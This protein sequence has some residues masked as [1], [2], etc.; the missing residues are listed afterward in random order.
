MSLVG[1]RIGAA[2]AAFVMVCAAPSLAAPPRPKAVSTPGKQTPVGSSIAIAVNGDELPPNPSPRIVG[3]GGG[4][5]V[6]P[7]VRIYSALGIAVSR[8][9][10]SITASAPGK[11]I[12][13]RI[14]SSHATIDGRPVIMEAPAMTIDNATYVPL[15]FVAESLGA[16]ATFNRHANRV[17]VVSSLVGRNPAL[18]QH[19]VGGASQIVGTVS[20]VD[21]NSAPQ[22][23]TVERGSNVRTVAVTSS[24]KIEL[25]DVVARTG[26]PGAFTD[27]HV[28]DAVSAIVLRD[29][30]VDSVIVRYASRIGTIAAVSPSQFVLNTGFIVSPDKSTT[31][32]LNALPATF[33]D[34]KVGDAVVVRL[35]PDTNEKRQIIVS[36]AIAATD[37][38]PGPAAITAFT[39]DAPHALRAG[40]S[41]NVV[42]RGTPGG[43]ATFDIGT[44]LTGLVMNEPQPGVYSARYTI[45]PNVNFGQTSVYGHLS[46]GGADAKRAEAPTLLAVSSTPPQIVDI[47]PLN[48]QSVNND[49]PSIYA[50]FRTPTG[51]T[52]NPSSAQISVNGQDVTPSA[53]RT[54][55]FITYS[56]GVA[57]SDGNVQVQVRVADQAGNVQTRTW[58]FTIHAR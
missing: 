58:S 16:Q 47:A 20:A 42:M 7:V 22:S 37:A 35:N 4:R 49:R 38:A 56:P 15:R 3:K 50:T 23:L 19:A 30:R 41:F 39:I 54:D 32:T 44:Y 10:D 5:L 6:V 43:R 13:L 51:V 18:E 46:A 25:Q 40:D 24:A 48:G 8:N 52:I 27:V 34:L 1:R 33:G 45:P 11:T 21:L 53:T 9:G 31:I 28:G 57:L 26:T 2:L 12:V 55:Q 14:G 29:G 17:E 36:R